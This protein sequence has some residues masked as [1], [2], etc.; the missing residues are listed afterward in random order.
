MSAKWPQVTV[1]KR[2]TVMRGG[3]RGGKNVNH[4]QITMRTT[5]KCGEE[6]EVTD[7]VHKDEERHT[8]NA[9]RDDIGIKARAHESSCRK[10]KALQ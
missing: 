1:L 7:R 3:R 8:E 10:C 2:P 4:V 5:V 6:L 9:M